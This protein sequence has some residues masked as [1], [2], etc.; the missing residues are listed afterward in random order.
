[1]SR[2]TN[3][4]AVFTGIG[5]LTSLQ[6]E[7]KLPDATNLF[8]S[9]NN[10][11]DVVPFQL[12]VLK[13]VVG[14]GALKDLLGELFTS[15][16]DEVT[17]K[18]GAILIKQLTQYNSG[19]LLSANFINSGY[20]VDL[21]DIDVF[22]KFKSN[23]SSD[24]GSL[25][26]SDDSDTFDR[27]MYNAI[28]NDGNDITVNNMVLKYNAS[29]DKV[30]LKPVASITTPNVGD[31]MADFVNDSVI[32]DKKEFLSN[33]MNTIYG[34]VTANQDKTVEQVT[35]ELEI[36]K[37]IEQL[38]EDDDSFVISEE[39][40]DELLQ[41]AQGLVDGVVYYD[42]GCGI[43]E[44]QLPLS[45]MTN[46]IAQISGSTDSY[47]VGNAVDGTID[48]SMS[49]TP[50]VAK[51][52][53]QTIKDGFFQRLIQ[54]IALALS[55]AL[56]VAPQIRALLAISS[57]LINGDVPQIGNPLDD[58]K[59]FSVFLKCVI[60]DVMK[61]ISKFIFDTVVA[62]L[63]ALITPILTELVREKIILYINQLRAMSP[64]KI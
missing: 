43:I 11:N 55:Q 41:K 20:N 7:R 27:K 51:E 17:P 59:K 47:A 44:A 10:V 31:W 45:G 21:K 42:M 37:L 9:V 61:L 38:I 22:D 6:Q 12:D 46:L 36:S 33:V 14:S 16:V 50:E 52:N 54:A 13:T 58:L 8:P 64:I 48:E 39:D 53:E 28:L 49:N 35:Q 19:Q 62:Y 4:G 26:Y 5:T 40:F 24:T 57:G 30:N 3:K 15:F 25:L 34:S 1:M 63:I 29:T 2:S 18:M 56:T 32:V 23:P 60:K